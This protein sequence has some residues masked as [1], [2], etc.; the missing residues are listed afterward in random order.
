VRNQLN[1]TLV[2][3]RNISKSITKFFFV[4]FIVVFTSEASNGSEVI[5]IKIFKDCGICPEM[6]KIPSGT[7]LMGS[8]KVKQNELPVHKVTIQKP[9]AVSRFEI[10]FE[11][12]DVCNTEGGCSRKIDDR[13]WGRGN[14]PVIN[15]LYSDIKEYIDWI[16]NK[17]NQTYR[18]PSEAEWEYAARAGTTTEYWWGDEMISG[19]ANCRGCGTK[20]SGLMSAPVGSFKPNPWGLYDLHGNLLEYVEDC[21]VNSH[22]YVTDDASPMIISNCHSRVIKGG[23]WYYLPRASRSAYR[24]RNDTRIFSYLIGFRVFRE[25]N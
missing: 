7:F 9:L 21:W 6:V 11:Q 8:G 24:A 2:V 4:F 22:K 12:W 1:Q 13:N 20:W 15:V 25:L 5:S 10:T 16:S 18:L 14:R 3:C 17:T 19:Y 23:A